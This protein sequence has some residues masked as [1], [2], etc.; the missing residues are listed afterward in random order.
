MTA[1]QQAEFDKIETERRKREEALLLILLLMIGGAATFADGTTRRNPR[2]AR[3]RSGQAVDHGIDPA[4]AIR[5]VVMGN[6]RLHLPGVVGILA[7]AM[8]DTADAATRH[9]FDSA[10]IEPTGLPTID[11]LAKAYGLQATVAAQGITDSLVKMV[12]QTIADAT[13]AQLRTQ[14]ISRAVLDSFTRYGWTM[15]PPQVIDPTS[16]GSPGWAAA[17]KATDIVLDAWKSG[18]G[19]GWRDRRIASVLT[20]FAHMSVIDNRTSTICL[21]RGLPPLILPKDD[22]YWRENCPGLH[23]R[24][25][26]ALIG[27]FGPQE[28]STVYPTT[29]PQPGYGKWPLPVF[30]NWM[31]L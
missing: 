16:K 12:E 28:W 5:D 30:P 29:K 8:A 19:M 15:A 2:S 14:Q 20:G 7:N 21:E 23:A 10:G 31:T 9:V 26:S 6:P 27:A 13:A 17:G 25:R 22:P 4:D 24:C 18:S 1:E 11:E 3:A